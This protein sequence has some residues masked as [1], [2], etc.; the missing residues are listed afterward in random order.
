MRTQVEGY[1]LFFDSHLASEGDLTMESSRVE[2]SPGGDIGAEGLGFR[3]YV[4]L[5]VL[6]TTP[7]NSGPVLSNWQKLGAYRYDLNPKP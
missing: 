5:L 6:G 4:D 1:A 3:V 2:P 7:C